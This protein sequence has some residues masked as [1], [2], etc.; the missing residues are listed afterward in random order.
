[1]PENTNTNK[2]AGEGKGW[3]DGQA[4]RE[5]NLARR[6]N[7]AN[8]ITGFRPRV[9]VE[10]EY[11]VIRAWCDDPRINKSFS[12]LINAL[13]PGLKTAVEHTTEVDKE[14]VL[15]IELNLGRIDIR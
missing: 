10:A 9:G 1:M 8:T 13:I 7:S 6:T 11:F 12:A 5:F 15:S 14:G 3:G 4:I 2:L